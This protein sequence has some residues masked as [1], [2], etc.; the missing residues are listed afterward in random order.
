GK[1][2]DQRRRGARSGIDLTGLVDAAVAVAHAPDPLGRQ[3][4]P[5]AELVHRSVG[6]YVDTIGGD[7]E[8]VLDL[9][10]EDHGPTAASLGIEDADGAVVAADEPQPPLRIR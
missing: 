8:R 9:F 7:C 2:P 10:A 5:G 3:I 4:R 1:R 6:N